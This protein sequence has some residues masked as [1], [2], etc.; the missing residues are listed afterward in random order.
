MPTA[1]ARVSTDRAGRYL[2]QLVSHVGRM[3]AHGNRLDR[4]GHGGT[5][6][7]TD[8]TRSDAVLSLDGGRCTLHASD[9]ALILHAEADDE[10]RLRE[11]TGRIAARLERIGG[12]DA[13]TVAWHP[14]APDVGH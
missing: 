2:T 12:R 3:A 7:P 8:A 5:A 13:L 11:I 4:H 6:L 10:P 9:S 1:H 14:G